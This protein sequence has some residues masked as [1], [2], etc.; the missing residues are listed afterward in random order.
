[1]QLGWATKTANFE[2]GDGVGVGD[3]LHSFGYDGCRNLY[4]VGL[5]FFI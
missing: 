5:C 2:P 4:W 3:E 1:M